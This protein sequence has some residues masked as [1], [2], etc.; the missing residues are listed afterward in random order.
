MIHSDQELAAAQAQIAS[1]QRALAEMR[2]SATPDE[3]HLVARSSRAMIERMQREVLDYLT[4]LEPQS[5]SASA[6]G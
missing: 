2:R 4:K 5:T 3:F 1:M 6:T